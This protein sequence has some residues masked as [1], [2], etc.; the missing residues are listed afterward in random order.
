[1]THSVSHQKCINEQDAYLGLEAPLS[2]G[3]I[4]VCRG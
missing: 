3:T 4:M 1:M 2:L